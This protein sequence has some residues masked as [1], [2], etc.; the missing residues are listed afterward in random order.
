VTVEALDGELNLTVHDNG[1]GMSPESTNSGTRIG[2]ASM[3]ERAHLVKGKLSIN[4]EH[5]EG[6]Q[7]RVVVPLS[8][9]KEAG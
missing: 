2:I 7:V 1:I 8:L 3:Q 5:G 4:S 6:T 9:E